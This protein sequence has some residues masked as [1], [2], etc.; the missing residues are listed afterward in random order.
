MSDGFGGS[1]TGTITLISQVFV[2]G[3]PATVSTGGS[4]ATVNFAGIPGYSYSIQRSTN[5]VDWAAIWTTN[6]PANG[7]FNYTDTFSDLGFVPGVAYYRL[8]Y[9]P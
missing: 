9:N 6:A 2:T 3:Q 1:A 5:L 8:Q 7:L 4:T